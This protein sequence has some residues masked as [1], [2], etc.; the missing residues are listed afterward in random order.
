MRLR[1]HAKNP[2]EAL[3]HL[4]SGFQPHYSSQPHRGIKSLL[5][6]EVAFMSSVSYALPAF[7][8]RVA[9]VDQAL[10]RAKISAQTSSQFSLETTTD[11][12][13]ALLHHQFSIP[14]RI[15]LIEGSLPDKRI[16]IYH[17]HSPVYS[18]GFD[19]PLCKGYLRGLKVKE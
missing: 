5:P 19:E 17:N 11:E 6:E 16:Q 2:R 14:G 1:H 8:R 3:N 10:R 9:Q 12:Q 4:L 15:I 13:F 7:E 18:G